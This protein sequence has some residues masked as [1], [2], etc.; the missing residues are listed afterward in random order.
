LGASLN[1][2]INKTNLNKEMATLKEDI[3]KQSD[4]II[5]ALN[6]DGYILDYSI[7]SFKELDRFLEDNSINGKPKSGGRL[8]QNLGS[9]L[10]SIGS[11]IGET[12]IKKAPGSEWITDDNDPQGEITASIKFPNGMTVWPMQRV[13]NRFKN[14]FEDS[15]YPYG[16]EI[17]KEYID[18][19]FD[20]SFWDLGKTENHPTKKS[21]WKLWQ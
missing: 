10:F 11:Y 19:S 15:I 8:T 13:I 16:Y 5:K 3:V 6:S 18:E 17:A 2:P 9:I 20:S 1:D 21:W 14:G 12:F 7:N 4:W